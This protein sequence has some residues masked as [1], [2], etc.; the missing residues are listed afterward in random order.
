MQKFVSLIDTQ[1]IDA[2][3]YVEKDPVE[4]AVWDLAAKWYPRI[5]INR[6]GK[7]VYVI[8]GEPSDPKRVEPVF[9][10]FKRL[11]FTIKERKGTGRFKDIP[12]FVAIRK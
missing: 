12:K 1:S 8:Y 9:K 6:E 2:Q 10:E 7:G 5:P 4:K 3:E 11:G